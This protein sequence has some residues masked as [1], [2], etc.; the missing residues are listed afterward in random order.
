MNPGRCTQMNM[1]F[2]Y[3]NTLVRTEHYTIAFIHV[4]IHSA[5]LRLFHILVCTKMDIMAEARM[6]LC[7]V[8]MGYVLRI[9]HTHFVMEA[10][11]CRH[12]ERTHRRSI[13]YSSTPAVASSLF[14]PS[15]PYVYIERG[16]STAALASSWSF[17]AAT[18]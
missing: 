16:T 18:I 9:C 14:F 4:C 13:W 7:A 5:V 15:L 3:I 2:V 11:L 1:R 6:S 8:C 12:F 10:H 17:R